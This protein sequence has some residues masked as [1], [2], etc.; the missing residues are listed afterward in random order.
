MPPFIIFKGKG[1]MEEKEKNFLDSLDIGYYFTESGNANFE[2][3]RMWLRCFAAKL[4][5]TGITSQQLLILDDFG[6]HW[7]EEY[8]DEIISSNIFP[9]PIPG[10]MSQTH[11]N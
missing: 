4:K 11:I 2:Y 6:T 1:H 10:G 3:H 7:K 8:T 5:E 9:F